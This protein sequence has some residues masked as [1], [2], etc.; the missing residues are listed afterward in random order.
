MNKLDKNEIENILPHRDPFLFV[1]EITDFIPGEYAKG[2]KY[3]SEDEYYFKGHFPGNPI[4]PGV[5]LVETIAQVGAVMMLTL[6][7]FKGKIALFA[8]IEK[9]RFKRIV[10]P[11]DILNIEVKIVSLKLNVGKGIG[12]VQVDGE[13]ACSA[14][15]LFSIV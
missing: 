6:K 12:R 4:M 11:G 9:A 15:L 3:V 13:L 5:I 2:L 1:D 7:K 14:E 8:G 10:K